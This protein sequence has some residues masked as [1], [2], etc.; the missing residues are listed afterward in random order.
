MRQVPFV[1][2]VL[3]AANSVFAQN[4]NEKIQIGQKAPSFKGLPGVDGKSY[5]LSDFT[6]DAKCTVLVITCNHCPVA[7]AYEERL[8]QFVKDYE[9]KG[10]KLV[11]I[12]VNNIDDDKLPKMKARAKEKGFNFA[13][14]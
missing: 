8:V 10:V 4:T 14:L 7:Q 3:L 2:L 9:P 12:N 6:K 11:A 1:A 13:Y 5:V